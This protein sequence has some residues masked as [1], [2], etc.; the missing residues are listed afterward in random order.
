MNVLIAFGSHLGST[1]E[2]AA[3]I[4][5]VLRGFG[6][7]VSVQPAASAGPVVAYDAV[8]VGGGTYAGR[9]HP[10]AAAFIR[11]NAV[12]LAARPTWLFSSGPLGTAGAVA[13]RDPVD[14]KSLASLVGARG[15]TIFA[16]S[17]DRATVAGSDLSRLE[18]F[19]AARFVP[20]GDWRDWP[21]IEAWARTIADEL[22]PTVHAA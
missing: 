14:L 15:H 13:P 22:R 12:E 7:K 10:D 11:T 3:R 2:I 9:W 16:G 6:S 18:R 17:H 19:V 1:A 21:A 5:E 20:E 8:I 4:A